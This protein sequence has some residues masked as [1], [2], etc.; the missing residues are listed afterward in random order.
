MSSYY[1][2][3]TGKHEKVNY[4]KPPTWGSIMDDA[5]RALNPTDK[6]VKKAVDKAE[7]G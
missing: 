6:K 4:K 3:A 1:N 2:R 7:K 5:Q